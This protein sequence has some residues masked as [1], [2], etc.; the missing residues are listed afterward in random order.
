MNLTFYCSVLIAVAV[1][2]GL[3]YVAAENAATVH[4]TSEVE[5]YGAVSEA[6]YLRGRQK[7]DDEERVAVAGPAWYATHVMTHTSR[8]KLSTQNSQKILDAVKKRRASSQVGEGPCGSY[9]TWCGIWCRCCRC[10]D[11]ARTIEYQ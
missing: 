1:A 7:V 2:H 3:H 11:N 6:R 4:P 5:S 9:W 10:E 8:S